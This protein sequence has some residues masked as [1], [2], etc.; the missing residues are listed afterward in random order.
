M[1][2][3]IDIRRDITPQSLYIAWD[4]NG[5]AQEDYAPSSAELLET[6]FQL[7][8]IQDYTRPD[9]GTIDIA[10]MIDGKKHWVE[11]ERWLSDEVSEEM[12]KAI[13]EHVFKSIIHV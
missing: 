3:I 13:I 6:L 5:A 10:L 2:E 8:Y 7:D 12:G 11:F 9:G 1:I 4:M